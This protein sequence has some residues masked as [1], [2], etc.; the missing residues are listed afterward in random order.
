MLCTTSPLQHAPRFRE[1]RVFEERHF[2][3]ASSRFEK[4]LWVTIHSQSAQNDTC[5][6]TKVSPVAMKANTSPT[7]WMLDA[8]ITTLVVPQVWA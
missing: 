4:E 3:T 2:D 6:L 1:R 8:N 5:Y 7:N